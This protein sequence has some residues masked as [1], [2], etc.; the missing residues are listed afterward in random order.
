MK[1]VDPQRVR[2]EHS[3]LQARTRTSSCGTRVA[4]DDK[5]TDDESDEELCIA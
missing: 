3:Q 4:R 2:K 1:R 5:T